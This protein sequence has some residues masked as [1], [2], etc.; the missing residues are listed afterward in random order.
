[1][2][3]KGILVLTCPNFEGFDTLVLKELSDTIDHEHLNYFNPRS[4]SLLLRKI[5]FEIIEISTPGKL[6]AELVRKKALNKKINLDNQLFL[7]TILI[8]EWE[9]LGAKFQNFISENLLSSHL[10]I[11]SQKP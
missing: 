10:W 2:A 9:R 3:R 7:K 5:G 11:V 8:D 6:D 4:I 1:M